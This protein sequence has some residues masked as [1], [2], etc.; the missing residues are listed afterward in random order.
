LAQEEKKREGMK[1][2]SETSSGKRFEVLMVVKMLM[3]VVCV[4]MLRL[5][6]GR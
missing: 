6:V 4:L 3:L 2:K 1:E 5:L